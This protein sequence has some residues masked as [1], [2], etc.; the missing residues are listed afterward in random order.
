MACRG[1][2]RIKCPVCRKPCAVDKCTIIKDRNGG[3]SLGHCTKLD[4]IVTHMLDISSAD[5]LVKFLVFPQW[6]DMLKLLEFALI[7]HEI[8]CVTMVQ[9]NV[10]L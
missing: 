2:N 6:H 8:S 10:L 1:R 4:A 9:L 3:A 5:P 7:Q